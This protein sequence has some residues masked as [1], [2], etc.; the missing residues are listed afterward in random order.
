MRRE[1]LLKTIELGR[2]LDLKVDFAFKQ[3]FGSEQNKSITIGFLNAILQKTNRGTIK[4][5]QF[6]HIEIVPEHLLNKGA[7]LDILND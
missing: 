1:K 6:Q 7:R 4:N 3:L 5:I 2:L